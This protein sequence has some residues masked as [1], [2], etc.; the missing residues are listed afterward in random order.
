MTARQRK[1]HCGKQNGQQHLKLDTTTGATIQSARNAE[2]SLSAVLQLVN[3]DLPAL[4]ER[5]A[6]ALFNALPVP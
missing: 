3:A 4:L 6:A 1:K 2:Q 5:F